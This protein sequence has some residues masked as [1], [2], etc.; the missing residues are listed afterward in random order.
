[1]T[2]TF[3]VVVAVAVALVVGCMGVGPSVAAAQPATPNATASTPTNQTATPNATTTTDDRGISIDV[4]LGSDQGGDETATASPTPTPGAAADA[5]TAAATGTPIDADV[6]LVDWSYAGGTFTLVFES[7]S[8]RP[9]TVTISEAT[10]PEEGAQRS[11]IRRER[12]LKGRTTITMTT[13]I[14]GGE[15]AV[16]ITTPASIEAG[17]GTTISTGAQGSNPFAPFGGTSGVLSGVGLSIVMAGAA[18]AWV[19]WQEETGV[20]EA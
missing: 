11:A 7:T 3:S 17:H 6:T 4:N 20:I 16:S 19:L 9:T 12:L 8:V 1:M 15:S 5:P 14:Q 18:A 10:Q 13:K 2:R